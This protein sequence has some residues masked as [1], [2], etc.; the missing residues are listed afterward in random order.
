M[1]GAVLHPSQPGMG[2]PA[3]F[4]ATGG[5]VMRKLIAI[6]NVVAWGGFWAFGYLALSADPSNTSQ[7]MIA[8]ALATIGGA[9]GIWAYLKLVRYSEQ[10]GYAKAPK[11]ADK[12][13]LEEHNE[14]G[15]SL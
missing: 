3:P 6:L 15:E 7:I 4:Q 13:H 8:V 11:W 14:N 10:S 1:S 2:A 12:S 5:F 9:L